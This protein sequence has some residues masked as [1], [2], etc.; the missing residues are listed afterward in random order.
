MITTTASDAG[1]ETTPMTELDDFDLG[2]SG[3]PEGPSGGPRGRR[4][5]L[6]AILALAVVVVGGGGLAAYL[7]SSRR[8]E[9]PAATP[10]QA[11]P[12]TTASAPSPSPF[13][14][15]SLPAL[16]ESDPLVRE[17]ARSL[18]RHPQVAVWLRSQ[19]LIR[20]FVAAV[21]N[22]AD[23][24]PPRAH[25]LFLAPQ[26][27]FTVVQKQG[28]PVIDPRSYG[29]YDTLAESV[30][31]LDAAAC[32]RAYRQTE[33]LL[34]AAYRDL[35]HPEGGFSGALGRALDALLATPVVDGDIAVRP[36][37]RAVL[38]YDL[39]DPKLEALAP[40]QKHLLRMGPRNVRRIQEKLRELRE[41]LGR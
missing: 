21:A 31:S 22:V 10:T 27:L 23:G 1:R 11:P 30:S 26:G 33:P 28:R 2:E 41:A 40:A 7:L 19:G 9:A 32:V 4:G 16:D 34:E 18:T 8:P 36:V 37:Q 35:G 25:V 38:V 3:P 39:V 5:H 13:A 17:L 20:A 6:G 14:P 29:R 12:P 24:E 15:T